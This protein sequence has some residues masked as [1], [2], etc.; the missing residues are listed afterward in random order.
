MAD[1]GTQGKYYLCLRAKFFSSA[2]HCLSNASQS[3]FGL[4]ACEHLFK[5]AVHLL[6]QGSLAAGKVCLAHG[7]EE[8]VDEPIASPKGC[9]FGGVPCG[10]VLIAADQQVGIAGIRGIGAFLAHTHLVS[11]ARAIIEV[12]HAFAVLP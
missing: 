10:E 5:V 9:D 12:R 1:P 4:I 2:R 11:P 3:T 8:P 6:E 7:T